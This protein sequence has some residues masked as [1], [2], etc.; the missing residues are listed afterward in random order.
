MREIK[1]N[2]IC[3]NTKAIE[4]IENGDILLLNRN[5]P[6]AVIVEYSH[7]LKMNTKNIA[8]QDERLELLKEVRGSLDLRSLRE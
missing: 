6:F 7:Y 8:S 1:L 3:D 2:N 5:K 4:N